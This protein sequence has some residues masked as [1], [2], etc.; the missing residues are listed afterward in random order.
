MNYP[1]NRTDF[2]LT[3]GVKTEVLFF[4]RDVDRKVVTITGAAPRVIVVDVHDNRVMLDRALTIVDATKGLWMLTVAAAD[5][6]FW[7]IGDMRYSIMIDRGVGDQVMLYTDRAYGPYSYLTVL[8]GPFPAPPE[9]QTIP[10]T[11]FIYTDG[12]LVSGAF[13]GGASI[14][15]PTGL[16][17]F[18]FSATKFLGTYKVEASIQNQP[19]SEELDWFEVWKEDIIVETTGP[20]PGEITGQ[21]LWIRFVV[22]EQLQQGVPST[23]DK[24]VYRNF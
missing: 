17:T 7:S 14:G 3:K 16:H 23:F 11:E 19:S 2:K 18:A 4:I 15:N 24:V 6:E 5:I 21:F 12:R 22:I 20:V 1:V 9:A 8:Q 10:S 13:L